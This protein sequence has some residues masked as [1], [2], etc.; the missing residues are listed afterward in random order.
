MEGHSLKILIMSWEL[1]EKGY[2]ISN[3]KHLLVQH[4]VEDFQ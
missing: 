4:V 1:R 2:H 3:K